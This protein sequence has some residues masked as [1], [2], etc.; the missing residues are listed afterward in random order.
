MSTSDDGLLVELIP[1]DRITVINPRKRNQHKFRE[2][3]D[4]IARVG[5]K[6]PIK[7]RRKAAA[8]D[9]PAY[10]LVYGQ[11]RL[12]AYI[13]LGQRQIPAI[14]DDVDEH[15]SLIMSLVENVAR[16]QRR[17]V[18]LLRE[19]ETL[20]ERGYSHADIAAK[21]G[22][23]LRRVGSLLRLLEAGEERLVTAVETG[24]IQ[25]D[26]ALEIAAADDDHV[27]EALAEA[28]EKGL[29]NG[30][31]L[32]KAR[33]LVEQRQKFGKA[34][35]RG[36]KKPNRARMSPAAL[37]RSLQTQADR[38][39]LLIKRA[40]ITGSRLQFIVEAMQL[41]LGDENFITLLRAENVQTLPRPLAD[42]I[43]ERQGG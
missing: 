12:E 40:E 35:G 19:I 13:A 17:A 42:L 31:Q 4:S 10:G 14:I 7:V 43:A 8:N 27:Q 23:S 5:L 33:F 21:I 20:K 1:V 9:E 15:D 36:S 22:Y 30:R 18:E 2:I 3:V 16:R 25:L 29:L 11:G 6:Q 34:P 32:R 37:V 41:L 26:A 39:R 38:Q 28:Y 24:Q